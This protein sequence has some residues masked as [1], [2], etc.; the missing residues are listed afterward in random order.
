MQVVADELS[1]TRQRIHQLASDLPLPCKC[2]CDG[3][4][5]VGQPG[6]RLYLP[7]HGPANRVCP[8]CGKPKTVQAEKC[9][10]CYW[11]QF[12][13]ED[14]TGREFGSWVVLGLVT[15]QIAIPSVSRRW[16]CQCGCGKISPVWEGNLLNDLTH[17]CRNCGYARRSVRKAEASH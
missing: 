10:D 6:Y 8:E 3:L 7:G 14:L 9:R 17:G 16:W 12:P 1:V 4:V 5:P 15:P 13:L 11:T 2:G